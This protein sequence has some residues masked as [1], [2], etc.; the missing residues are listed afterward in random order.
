[1][2]LAIYVIGVIAVVAVM[3]LSYFLGS[4]GHNPARFYPYESGIEGFHALPSRFFVHYFLVAITFVIFDLESAFL[5]IWSSSVKALGWIGF[6]QICIFAFMLMLS[7]AYAFHMGIF[8]FFAS[9][10]K[11]YSHE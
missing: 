8:S 2:A 9:G 1:M 4:R 3:L 10:A 7:L 6:W 11:D 5:Y